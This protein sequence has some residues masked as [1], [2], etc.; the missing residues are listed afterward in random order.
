M[1][2]HPKMGVTTCPIA[3]HMTPNKAQIPPNGHIRSGS[4]PIK[5]SVLVIRLS[6]I[7]LLCVNLMRRQHYAVVT[8]FKTYSMSNSPIY[9]TERGTKTHKRPCQN[10]FLANSVNYSY[11]NVTLLHS[12][13]VVYL[14][15]IRICCGNSF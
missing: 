10:W 14:E 6:Y 12:S 5:S 2:S 11:P 13:T 8:V 3:Q 7:I 4:W 1:T 15:E 9:D